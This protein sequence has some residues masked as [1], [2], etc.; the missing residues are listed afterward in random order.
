MSENEP[1]DFDE[2]AEDY[3]EIHTKNV[4][5]LSGADSDYFSEYKIVE[6][7]TLLE[8]ARILDFGCGDG[9]SAYFIQ[10]HIHGYEYSGIDVSEESVRKA[11]ERNLR[12]CEFSHYDGRHIPFPDE[13]F[14]VVFAAC[15]F[16]HIDEAEHISMLNEI[17]RVLRTGGTVI[18]FE[19]NPLNP[20]TVKTVRDCPFDVGVKLIQGGVLKR[21][22]ARSGFDAKHIRIIYTIFMPRTGFFKRLLALE[23]YFRK[24]PLGGQYYCIARK[25]K[26]TG[27]ML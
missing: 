21:R 20:L 14:D 1:V 23:K 25:S 19:H 18:V 11:T 4:Q 8:N 26:P 7:A 12:G 24:I 16:H 5:S 6:V 13:T 9:N 15:V 27:D 17:R 22:L 3:R 2:F 10:K